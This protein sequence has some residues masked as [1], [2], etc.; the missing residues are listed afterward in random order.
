ME[1][2]LAPESAPL[3]PMPP[4]EHQLPASDVEANDSTGVFGVKGKVAFAMGGGNYFLNPPSV[5][6]GFFIGTETVSRSVSLD[7]KPDTLGTYTQALR[8]MSYRK[9]FTFES[10]RLLNSIRKAFRN[11]GSD[12]SLQVEPTYADRDH[13]VTGVRTL[14]AVNPKHEHPKLRSAIS[15]ASPVLLPIAALGMY[16]M[17]DKEPSLPNPQAT[18]TEQTTTADLK[19]KSAIQP[20]RVATPRRD[21]P[22]AEDVPAPTETTI[23]TSSPWK[24]LTSK[25]VPDNEIMSKVRAIINLSNGELLLVDQDPDNNDDTD[26]VV[27]TDEGRR[28]IA[29]AEW[30]KLFEE[31]K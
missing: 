29:A 3:P 19:S 9:A 10:K 31:S 18:G 25:G 22:T 1:V 7:Y 26:V 5:E 14:P 15:S 11:G 6:E 12:R 24:Y 20:S 23:D 4:K 30:I 8:V 28:D 2:L 27:E 16:L 13:N 17:T 21:T